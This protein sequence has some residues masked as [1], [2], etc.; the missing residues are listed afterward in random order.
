MA[1]IGPIKKGVELP[2]L[3]APDATVVQV[4][5]AFCTRVVPCVGRAPEG[6]TG[7]PDSKVGRSMGRGLNTWGNR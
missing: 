6:H 3:Q 1:L 5:S 4:P 7:F 2:H